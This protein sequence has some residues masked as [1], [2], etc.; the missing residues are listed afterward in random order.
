ML[1]TA[2]RTRWKTEPMPNTPGTTVKLA[3]ERSFTSQEY[4]HLSNGFIPKSMDDKWFIFMEGDWLYFHRSWS[5]FCIYQIRF[6]P[7]GDGYIVAEVVANR[8]KEQYG[9][10]S[11]ETDSSM[12]VYLIDKLLLRR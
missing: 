8:N 3:F 1:K 6:K 9:E 2:T 11:N 5:G 4:A 12:L 10:T 7:N